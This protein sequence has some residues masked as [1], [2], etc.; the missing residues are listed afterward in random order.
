MSMIFYPLALSIHKLHLITLKN[1]N[2][3]N[4]R[5]VYFLYRIL[6]YYWTIKAINIWMG[7]LVSFGVFFGFWA[8]IHCKWNNLS[9]MG[10]NMQS[11][12][13]INN[14]L[15]RHLILNNYF[16]TYIKSCS[17]VLLKLK[18]LT[19]YLLLIYL[20]TLYQDSREYVQNFQ[21]ISCWNNTYQ[22]YLIMVM[23]FECC[24]TNIFQLSFL[25]ITYLSSG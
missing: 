19:L 5:S 21:I 25:I 11:F 4:L 1:S 3:T 24:C 16:F 7:L 18:D 15:W 10:W 8:I 20:D 13:L 6:Q 2:E 23:H 17:L 9:S 12:L 14:I 22:I